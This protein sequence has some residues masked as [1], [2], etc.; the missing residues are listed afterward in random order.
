MS[1]VQKKKV[2]VI[3]KMERR[4][5]KTK[6]KYILRKIMSGMIVS[7]ILIVKTIRENIKNRKKNNENHICK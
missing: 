7:K 5:S 2:V 6:A 4:N 3:T 1:T